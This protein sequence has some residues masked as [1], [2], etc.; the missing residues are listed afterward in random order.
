MPGP[1]HAWSKWWGDVH[2]A[3]MKQRGIVQYALAP[4]QAKV[5]PKMIRT[6]VFN[7]YRRVSAEA[8]YFVIPFAIAYGTYTWGNARYAHINSKAGHLE[9]GEHH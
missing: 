7:F 8:I 5:A 9:A 4:N 6:Y 3:G 1:Q 2:G